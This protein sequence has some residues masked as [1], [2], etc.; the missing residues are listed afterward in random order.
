MNWVVLISQY[1]TRLIH[2]PCFWTCKEFVFRLFLCLN[3]HTGAGDQK[4]SY[5][6]Q[7]P[8]TNSEKCKNCRAA[9]LLTEE[10][11]SKPYLGFRLSLL[12]PPNSQSARKFKK[13]QA[14]YSWN[15][16]NQFFSWNC[17]SGSFKLFPSSKIDFW[18]FLK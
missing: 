1:I 17:I 3:V 5:L 11:N 7:V 18:P 9:Q 12:S 8:H 4:S 2:Y 13:V 15:Q 10:E 14:Q 16:I 6:P